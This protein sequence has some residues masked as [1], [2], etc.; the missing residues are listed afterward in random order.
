VDAHIIE[1]RVL[2]V[3]LAHRVADRVRVL[4]VCR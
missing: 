1:T 2:R 4:L 3:V